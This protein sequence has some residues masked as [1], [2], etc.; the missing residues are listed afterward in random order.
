MLK[1]DFNNKAYLFFQ[2]LLSAPL[3]VRPIQAM[4]PLGHKSKCKKLECQFLSFPLEP[5]N[6]IGPYGLVF[7]LWDLIL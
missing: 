1:V 5:L 6:R 2:L 3:H 4:S 7:V